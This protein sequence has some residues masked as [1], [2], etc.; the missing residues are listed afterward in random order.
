MRTRISSKANH[1]LQSSQHSQCG[2]TPLGKLMGKTWVS[3]FP[4]YLP[5]SC[6]RLEGWSTPSRE[7]L[8]WDW[9]LSQAS[10][11]NNQSLK[12]SSC[13]SRRQM[14]HDPCMV[15]YGFP[16]KICSLFVIEMGDN[17]QPLYLFSL[18]IFI[19]AS[20]V[21]I[22]SHECSFTLKESLDISELE[23]VLWKERTGIILLV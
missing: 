21:Q 5:Y 3:I 7:V 2:Y 15:E 17:T 6:C 10:I 12:T 23:L 20:Q 14:S 11:P 8:G 16:I 9:M 19:S 22:L 18:Y 13:L 1:A 4:R